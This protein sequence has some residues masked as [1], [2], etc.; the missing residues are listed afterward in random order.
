MVVSL[1]LDYKRWRTSPILLV[2]IRGRIETIMQ[3]SSIP[4][5]VLVRSIIKVKVVGAS[6]L[7]GHSVAL[8]VHHDIIKGNPE[9]VIPDNDRK[10]RMAVVLKA[11]P[12]ASEKDLYVSLF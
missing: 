11:L 6:T 1:S 10:M 7:F 3:E 8:G 4:D 12:S 9:V 2:P 5:V